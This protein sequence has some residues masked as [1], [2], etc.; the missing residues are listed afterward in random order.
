MITTGMMEDITI[1]C[2]F[3]IPACF[4]ATLVFIYY[5]RE[6]KLRLFDA[7]VRAE[8]ESVRNKEKLMKLVDALGNE[9]NQKLNEFMHWMCH[10]YNKGDILPEQLAMWKPELKGYWGNW[11]DEEY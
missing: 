8:A 10:C 9:Y 7:Q 3:I 1:A 5:G 2:V 4:M 11:K 6:Q